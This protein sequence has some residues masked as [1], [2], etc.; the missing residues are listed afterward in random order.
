[1]LTFSSLR[2][3]DLVRIERK[4]S[5]QVE[6]NKNFEMIAV[7]LGVDAVLS[8]DV[9]KIRLIER[10]KVISIVFYDLMDVIKKI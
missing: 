3:G 4:F 5:T 2:V 6:K 8:E 7:F 1:M 9:Y 10:D